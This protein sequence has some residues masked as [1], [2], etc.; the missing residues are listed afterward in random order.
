M[1]TEDKLVTK[2]LY[3]YGQFKVC[4]LCSSEKQKEEVKSTDIKINIKGPRNTKI[5]GKLNIIPSRD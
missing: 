1:S 4:E 5:G 3:N 2:T